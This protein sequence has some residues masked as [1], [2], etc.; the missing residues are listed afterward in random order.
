MKIKTNIENRK[1]LVKA[2]AEI[3][4]EPSRYLGPPSFAYQIGGV[5]VD[6]DGNIEIEDVKE[7]KHLQEEL[8]SRG[9]TEESGEA[10]HLQIPMEGHTADSIRNLIYMIHSKQYLLKRSVG[11]EVLRVSE[12]L[13]ERLQEEKDADLDRVLQIFSEEKEHC[14]GLD[15]VDGKVVFNGFPFDAERSIAFAELTCMMA[16]KA[17]EMKRVSPAETIEANEKYYMR[18]WLVRLGLG[19]TGGKNTRAILLKN[20][21][22]HTAFRTEEEKQRAKERNKQ[23]MAERTTSA[24]EE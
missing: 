17:K 22:G 2:V 1:E 6:R 8:A 11:T 24:A 4:G 18:I 15:F 19:G 9:M 10:L 16:A 20:L 3:L 13:V 7:G 14:I 12:T 5:T 21:K 23:R